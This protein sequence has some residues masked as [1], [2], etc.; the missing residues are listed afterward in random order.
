MTVRTL[1][2]SIVGLVTSNA[3][4]LSYMAMRGRPH[5]WYCICACSADIVVNSLALF[6]A[7]A[8]PSGRASEG[9]VEMTEAV[10]LSTWAPQ[11]AGLSRVSWPPNVLDTATLATT[12]GE[13]A[14]KDERR[15]EPSLN[16]HDGLVTV[17]QAPL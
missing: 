17:P 6:W 16:T 13:E 4:L 11:G 10:K 15:H 14:D 12:F 2:A 5:A 7:T 3:N 1:V 8:T 9:D